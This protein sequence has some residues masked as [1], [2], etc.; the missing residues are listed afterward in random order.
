MEVR[1]LRIGNI[2]HDQNSNYLR[3]TDITQ[4][5]FTTY[6]IDRSKY[7]LPKGWKVEPVPITEEIL[8]KCGFIKSDSGNYHA[9]IDTNETVLIDY[10]HLY[11]GEEEKYFS[12]EDIY[13]NEV[14]IFS[15][16]QTP[17]YLHQLQNLYYFLTQKELNIEL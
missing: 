17:K 12:I 2:L 9:H 1:E 11:I 16:N 7:P 10:M 4:K 14:Y 8:L 13:R 15:G 3:V 6:V 5:G